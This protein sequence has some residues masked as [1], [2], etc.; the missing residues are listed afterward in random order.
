MKQA[1][2]WII[3][4]LLPCLLAGCGRKAPTQLNLVEWIHIT[5]A[6]FEGAQ[7]RYF[8]HPESLAK[9][10]TALRLT[11]LTSTPKEDPNAVNSTQFRIT[12][13]YADGRRHVFDIKGDRYI[14]NK[15]G[16]WRQLNPDNLAPLHYLLHFLP[17][18]PI[19]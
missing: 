14:R 12:M 13:A 4:C 17:G 15:D 19:H 1:K 2:R 18:D 7:E 11:G 10:L 6:T 5:G 16:P 8:Y 3:L 9:L